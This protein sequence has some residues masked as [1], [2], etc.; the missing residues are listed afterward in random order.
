MYEKNKDNFF[1]F[2]YF[3]SKQLPSWFQ[4]PTSLFFGKD[5]QLNRVWI[6]TVKDQNALASLFIKIQGYW[7]VQLLFPSPFSTH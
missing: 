2:F 3:A 1:F 7:R 4:L 5:V 6:I